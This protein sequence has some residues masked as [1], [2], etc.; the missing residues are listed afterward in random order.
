MFGSEAK[1]RFSAE[2]F[3]GHVIEKFSQGDRNQGLGRIMDQLPEASNGVCKAL[4][5]HWVA[6]HANDKPGR[7]SD[8]ARSTGQG[9]ARQ[10]G[11]WGGAGMV[12]T[13]LAYGDAIRNAPRANRDQAKDQFTDD[14]LRKQG[15]LRQMNIKYP[16]QNLSPTTHKIGSSK[17]MDTWFGRKLA[18]KIVGIHSANYWSYKIISLHG[19][20][21]GHA[22]AA[23]VGADAMFFD[24]NYGIFYFDK[25]DKFRLWFGEPGGFYWSSGYVEELGNDFVIKSY[26][27]SI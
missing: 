11:N 24:P 23:F 15:I 21:G 14:F 5:M 27:K 19:R 16:T 1:V 18:E 25:A 7:F 20:A 2:I 4:C 17:K 8:V 6:H 26:A 9:S 13:Q 12:V 10:G 3:K 22:V